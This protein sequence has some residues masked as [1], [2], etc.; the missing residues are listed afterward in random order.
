MTGPSTNFYVGPQEKHYTIP[1][2]L[3]DHFSGYA[4][5]C[6][7]GVSSESSAD[8]VWLLD[9]DP[10]VFQYLWQ[11]LYTGKVRLQ[12]FYASNPDLDDNQRLVQACQLLCQAHMLGERLLFD[13]RFL[14]SGVEM[15]LQKVIEEAKTEELPM[16]LR[17]D[18]VE[19][20]LSGF[21]LAQYEESWSS[22]T[23]RPVVLKHLCNFQFCTTVDFTDYENC[24]QKDGTFA[25]ELL[26]FLASEIKWAKERGEAQIGRQLYVFGIEEQVTGEQHIMTTSKLD[27]GVWVALRHI[28]TSEGYTTNYIRSFS[29]HFELNAAFAAAF[30]NQMAKELLWT[31]KRW[32]EELG[33]KVDVAA[34]KEREGW[35][36]DNQQLLNRNWCN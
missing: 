30:L 21:A 25:A 35:I 17:P 29:R 20:V 3:F 32:G 33:Q 15:Q 8:P 13:N 19:E 6:L 2:R 1:R 22:C 24:F 5:A 9:V 18:M 10:N 27:E 4:K 14:E 31:V 36:A 23:L 26:I 11:W 7:G 12:S 28:C 34:E 16:P